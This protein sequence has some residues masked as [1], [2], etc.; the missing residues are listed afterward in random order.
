MGSSPSQLS[1][2]VDYSI[3]ISIS[4]RLSCR[5]IFTVCITNIFPPRFLCLLV[6]RSHN[7]NRY[8]NHITNGL[9]GFSSSRL[10]K[11][12]ND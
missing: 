12:D 10:I 7:H 4:S 1:Q 11:T 2:D 8:H 6:S 9:R 3:S 5:L